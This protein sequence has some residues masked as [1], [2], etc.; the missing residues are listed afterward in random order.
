MSNEIV[1]HKAVDVLVESGCH[2][3]KIVLGIPA[4]GRDTRN[5]GNIKT[6]HEVV[7][8][9]VKKRIT[10]KKEFCLLKAMEKLCLSNHSRR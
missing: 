7:D 10:T 1:A 4:Y 2:P 8:A 5:P 3:S 9:L 6:H